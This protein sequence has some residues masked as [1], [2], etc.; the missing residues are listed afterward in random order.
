MNQTVIETNLPA[1]LI[2]LG[3]S[4]KEIAVYQAILL[5]GEATA[6]EIVKKAHLKRG[7][8]YAILYDFER[9]GLVIRMVKKGKTYFQAG[10]PEMLQSVVERK[11]TE[12]EDVSSELNRALPELVSHYKLAVNKPTVRYFQGTEGLRSVFKDIYA[13]KEDKVYGC[14]DLEI[15]DTVFPSHIVDDLIPLR[16]KNKLFAETLL[17][18]SPAAEEVAKDD[19]RQLRHTVLVD[20][21]EFPL[22]AEI[23][24]Y[25]DK[26][27]MLSFAK[28]EFVGIIIENK[29]LAESLRSIFKLALT[30]GHKGI[31]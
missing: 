11:K 1:I 12:V 30:T 9:K 2:K 4:E 6:G 7:I 15:A 18:A 13:P 24:V 28:G 16:I 8:T 5:L 19:Q 20:K 27:A 25:E 21:K 23:D 31:K 10:S 22:P 17:A 26:I 29:D 14:V 3:F